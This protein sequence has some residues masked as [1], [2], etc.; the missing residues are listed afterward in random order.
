M[1]HAQIHYSHLKGYWGLFFS[2]L[3]ATFFGVYLAHLITIPQDV[4]TPV[5][6]YAAVENRILLGLIR[7]AIA[8]L[9]VGI[10]F[11][12]H[13]NGTGDPTITIINIISDARATS[14]YIVPSGWTLFWRFLAEVAGQFVGAAFALLG[15]FVS[16]NSTHDFGTPNLNDEFHTN[17]TVWNTQRA[18]SAWLH[19][20]IASILLG[21]V[22]TLARR[23]AGS[24]YINWGLAIAVVV[25][26]FAVIFEGITNPMEFIFAAAASRGWTLIPEG[27]SLAFFFGPFIGKPIGYFIVV[28][29]DWIAMNDKA[30][31]G[32]SNADPLYPKLREGNKRN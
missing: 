32:E 19:N 15:A 4:D 24:L 5:G 11:P 6:T 22:W 8:A 14:D 26:G 30:M 10:F 12:K 17:S 13:G 9:T 27:I 2:A 28:L 20:I 31:R 23:R 3:L 16:Y 18:G 7:G 1:G 25:A 29:Y 21:I